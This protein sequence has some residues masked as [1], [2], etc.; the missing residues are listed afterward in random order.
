MSYN[1]K[2]FL[3]HHRAN[4]WELEIIWIHVISAKKDSH[5][6][7][8]KELLS[9]SMQLEKLSLITSS[10]LD[11]VVVLTYQR[12]GQ[13]TYY[14][15]IL[16]GLHKSPIP[17]CSVQCD[18]D[19][20]RIKLNTGSTHLIVSELYYFVCSFSFPFKSQIQLQVFYLLSFGFLIRNSASNYSTDERDVDNFCYSEVHSRSC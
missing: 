13:N 4:V 10:T 7:Q 2:H 17:S 3:V 20:H 6:L 11:L 15:E 9:L 12:C 18:I 5:I 14:S 8:P 1:C 16:S 19:H